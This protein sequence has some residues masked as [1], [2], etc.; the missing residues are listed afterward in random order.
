MRKGCDLWALANR[1]GCIDQAIEVPVPDAPSRKKLVRLYARGMKLSDELAAEAAKRTEGVG[2]A[3]IKEPTRRTTQGAIARW[4]RGAKETVELSEADLPW[5]L[6]DM[7]FNDGAL[8]MKL[9]GGA[10]VEAASLMTITAQA[11]VGSESIK[12]RH[13]ECPRPRFSFPIVGQRPPMRG[14][15]YV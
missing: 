6:G 10:G 2:A 14:G 4:Q 12:G 8:N 7:L 13:F 15:S 5:A 11:N 1:P 3:L 9:L